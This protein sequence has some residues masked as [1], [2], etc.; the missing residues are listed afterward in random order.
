MK[1]GILS[2]FVL[3]LRDFAT[4]RARPLKDLQDNMG[5]SAYGLCEGDCDA[6]SDCKVGWTIGYI[7]QPLYVSGTL[8]NNDKS[9]IIAL[10]LL[11]VGT[12]LFSKKWNH[13][14]PRLLG[15]WNQQ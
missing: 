4:I 9:D 3:V 10:L 1:N 5:K 8:S 11:V 7:T 12:S 6:D 14:S 15:E 13:S 2:L